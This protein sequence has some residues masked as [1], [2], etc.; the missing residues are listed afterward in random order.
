[1]EYVPAGVPAVVTAVRVEV[2]LVTD[3]VNV[4]D[5]G[6][7]EQVILADGT[8]V[9]LSATAPANPLVLATVNTEVPDDPATTVTDTGF[10]ALSVNEVSLNPGQAVAN[11]LPSTDPRPVASS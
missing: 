7:S 9:Q 11:S 3:P 1:M 4:T 2:P 8:P 5:V 10:G 6:L